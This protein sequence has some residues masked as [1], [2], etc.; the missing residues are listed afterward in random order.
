MLR[1]EDF[2]EVKMTQE[3]RIKQL[4]ELHK[5]DENGVTFYNPDGTIRVFIPKL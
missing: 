2:V 4:D 3:E 5:K 1:N